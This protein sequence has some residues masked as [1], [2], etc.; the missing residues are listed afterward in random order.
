LSTTENKDREH[1]TKAISKLLQLVLVL[2]TVIII[3]FVLLLKHLPAY[4]PASKEA[5]VLPDANGNFTDAAKLIALQQRDTIN[6]WEAPDELSLSINENDMVM[7]GK[8]LIM[9]TSVY[10]GTNGKLV[11]GATNGM[12]CQNCHLDAGTKI[13]G[14]NYSSVLSTY[15]K[16]RARS[17][18]TENIYKRVNDC[19]E[20]SLN[21]RAIDT[22]SKEMQAIVS[23]IH[24]LGKNV[25]KGKKAAGSGLKDIT[26]MDRAASAENGKRVYTNTCQS[27]H[28]A[29]GE[30]KLNATQTE[31]TY[32]PLWG[33]NSY[34]NG[35]GLYRLSNF[36]KF[37]KY[38]M[39]QG[40]THTT[41]Q[42][43]DE[44]AWDVA[45]FVNSQ[46]RPLKDMKKDWPKTQ[47][48]PFDHPYSPYADG[49]DEQEHK[50]GPFKEIKNKL[51]TLQYEKK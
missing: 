39:P 49:F 46:T 11:K 12:N 6:Y 22:N 23:Y 40:V 38:N 5:I 28:Q 50:Y 20:R 9:H 36:A 21:G 27:C 7:Y 31:Y 33:N 42:L 43:T 48:K 25:A 35:A 26:F 13:Y 17:G 1:L 3:L 32:P 8:E 18:T 15:P 19:F 44:E 37:V 30:G 51:T 2:L 34:N 29:N 4:V 10:Y 16:Y 41:A 47:E 14:N 45:A 24:W